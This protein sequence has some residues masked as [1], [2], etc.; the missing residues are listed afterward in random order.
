M[1]KTQKMKNKKKVKQETKKE[2]KKQ[3]KQ[4]KCYQIKTNKCK[5]HSKQAEIEKY[6]T[7]RKK[8]KSRTKR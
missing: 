5:E 4:K 7:R 1:K 2:N 3:M 8:A 6:K